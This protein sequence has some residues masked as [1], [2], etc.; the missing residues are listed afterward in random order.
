MKYCICASSKD[1]ICII[2]FL[3]KTIQEAGTVTTCFFTGEKTMVQVEVRILPKIT[4]LG[5]TRA[6]IHR[7]TVWLQ[8]QMFPGP[9]L[10]VLHA[11]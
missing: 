7:Q 5:S 4:E 3:L 11:R 2:H 9:L 1:F 6:R 8:S 10:Q